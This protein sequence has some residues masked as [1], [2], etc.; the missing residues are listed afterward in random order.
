MKNI[1]LS[2]ESKKA[3]DLLGYQTLT[4]IQEKVIPLL[5]ENKNV[6]V[7]A[8]T[9]SGKTCSYGLPLCEHIN[10]ELNRPQ[11][12]VLACTRELVTQIQEECS[13]LGKWH[14]IKV[15]AVYGKES[16]DNQIKTLKQKCH[17]LVATPGRLLDL[18]ERNAVDLS[19][20]STLIIDEADYLLDLGFLEDI[21]T[22]VANLQPNV[23]KALFS[24]TYP[25]RIQD[26]IATFI[27]DYEVVEM[28]D[29]ATINHY[30]Y[31][32]K[33]PLRDL[34]CF[35]GN[36]DIESALVFCERKE[37]VD[38][39]Y[40]YFKEKGLK[41]AKIHGDLLQ[42]QRFQELNKFKNGKVR[43]LIASDV[44][45]RGI[46]IDSVTHVFHYGELQNQESYVHRCGR[47]G[48]M[49]KV[50]TS[51]FIIDDMQKAHKEL[52]RKFHIKEIKGYA[53]IDDA[54]IKALNT[55]VI[56]HDKNKNFDNEIEKIYINAGSEKKIRALD[57]IGSFTSIDN[58]TSQD[59]GV[60]EVLRQ[61]S[62]VEIYHGKA[63][64]IVENMKGKT[65]KK[66]NI[67]VERAK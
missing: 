17:I 12:L 11:A 9:G 59:I 8:K 16:I 13:L 62:Y 26:F 19:C 21:E 43:V 24:A 32:S 25:Q 14:K 52:I 53:N 60:I 30:Y 4:P 54:K 34:Y 27:D 2:I 35:I 39:L 41:V 29:E 18:I 42:K 28:K 37:E 33:S 38:T 15:Q 46:D 22:I 45:A 64:Y 23:Q 36:L 47:S 44:A 66:K 50:G 67:K 31:Q 49:D 5:L 6:V 20:V 58:I 57:I 7:Q 48:R 51:L 63:D 3:L 40:E 1:K 10:W 65:I 55:P 61:M 56:K